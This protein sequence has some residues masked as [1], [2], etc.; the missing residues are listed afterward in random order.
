MGTTP[1]Y[2]WPYPELTDP[3]DGATQ[4]KALANAVDTSLKGVDT[5]VFRDSGWINLTVAYQ[6]NWQAM[7]GNP[8]RGRRLGPIALVNLNAQRITTALTSDATG[9]FTDSKIFTCNDARFLPDYNT[10]FSWVAGAFG[11]HGLLNTPDPSAGSFSWLAQCMSGAS[12]SVNINQTC[13]GTIA[14]V[15]SAAY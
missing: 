1:N 6:A 10:W 11:I 12:S 4:I 14:Y 2:L 15:C 8:C 5:L 13:S 7:S 3:P 9:N